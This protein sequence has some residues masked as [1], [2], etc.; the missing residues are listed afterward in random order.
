MTN[1]VTLYSFRYEILDPDSCI[2][3][4][5]EDLDMGNLLSKMT[6]PKTSTPV[7]EMLEQ[8]LSIFNGGNQQSAVLDVSRLPVLS[9]FRL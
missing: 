9:E 1:T 2:N 3:E 7:T 6:A 4:S 5:Q 8:F